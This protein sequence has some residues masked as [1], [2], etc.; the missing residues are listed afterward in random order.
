MSI[1]AGCDKL[2]LLASAVIGAPVGTR[3]HGPPKDLSPDFCPTRRTHCQVYVNTVSIDHV[4]DNLAC[5][6][7][8]LIG[9]T[10]KEVTRRPVAIQ[11][12]RRGSSSM[13]AAAPMMS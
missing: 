7:I 11:V 8:G 9:T 13:F 1:P 4:E 2:L 12:Q 5:D 10:G 3:S 6:L